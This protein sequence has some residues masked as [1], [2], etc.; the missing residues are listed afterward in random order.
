MLW[1][2]PNTMYYVPDGEIAL[3]GYNVVAE[4][5]ANWLAGARLLPRD[6]LVHIQR[7]GMS[8][9]VACTKYG[10]SR[11]LLRYRAN[12]TSVNFQFDKRH[13]PH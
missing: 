12:V 2:D 5:E 6:A 10:V 9:S 4:E 13:P 1:H 11:D 7:T 8:D 3:W